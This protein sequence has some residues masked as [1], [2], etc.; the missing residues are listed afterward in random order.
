MPWSEWISDYD[1]IR[2]EIEAIIPGFTDFNR[3]VR[4]PGGFYLPNPAKQRAFTTPSGKAEFF[5]HPLTELALAPGQLILQ[6]M[7]SHDQFNTTVYGMNDRY[8]GISNQRCIVFLN[9]EDMKERGIRPLQPV[10][11]TSH[12]KGTE[13]KLENFLAIPYDQPKGMAAAYFPE[14][15]ALVP[16][17]STAAVSHTPTSKCVFVTVAGA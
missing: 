11:L 1:R 7:R 9:P 2:D 15:N 5:V 16:I 13:R 4:H 12:W 17:D 10:T 8:R 14:A 6:T 3:R